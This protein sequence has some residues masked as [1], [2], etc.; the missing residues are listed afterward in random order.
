VKLPAYLSYKPSGVGWMGA[1]PEGWSVAALKHLTKRI[2]DGAHIS[3]E[4]EDGVYPF[5]STRDVVG[6]SIDFENCLRTSEPSYEYMVRTGCRPTVGDVLFSKDGTIGRTVVVKD[7]RDFVVAS[8]LIIIRPDSE[9][10]DPSFLNR[11]CQSKVI[12]S[13]VGSLVQ[14]AGLPRLSIQNLLRVVGCFPPLFEQR[15]IAAFLDGETGRIDILV[16][17]KRTLVERLKEKRTALISRT[18]TRGLPPDAARAAGLDPHPNLKPSGIDWL[19]D[20]PA[21]WSVVPLKWRANCSSGDGIQTDDVAVEPESDRTIPVIGGNGRMGYTNGTNV[22]APVLIIGRVGALCGNVHRIS[23]PAWVTDNALVLNADPTTFDYAYLHLLLLSRNLNGLADKTAQPL[24]TGSQVRAQ[25]L[26]CPPLPE[27][28]VIATFLDGETAKLDALA[29]Q[30]ESA[31]D[32][33]Q[34]YRTALITA[35]VTGKIDVR[36]PGAK[37]AR[38]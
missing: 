7:D 14:G 19:G 23:P 15:R 32:R 31:I 36:Q 34:E 37:G 28:H 24:I 13:Q 5:V 9:R 26:P 25:R 10:L 21:H 27:Q 29:T 1:I 16:A 33:L 4:T 30:V 11:L 18:V 2:T 8:S 12:A 20:V 3:P 17:K 22:T 38:A 35:A 6:E